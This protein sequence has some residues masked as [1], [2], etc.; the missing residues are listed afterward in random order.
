MRGIEN[1]YEEHHGIRIQERPVLDAFNLSD[2][3]LLDKVIEKK[4]LL[5]EADSDTEN[6]L[7]TINSEIQQLE[8]E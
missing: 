7:Q 8:S 1:R 5:K 6:R 4:V 2:R 3:C